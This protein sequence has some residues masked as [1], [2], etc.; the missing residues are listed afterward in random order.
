VFAQQAGQRRVVTGD[1]R[2]FSRFPDCRLLRQN[3][4]FEEDII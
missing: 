4:S 3:A 2:L 1:E